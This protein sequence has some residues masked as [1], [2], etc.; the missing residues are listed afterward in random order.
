[1][2]PPDVGRE[3]FESI[4]SFDGGSLYWQ[5]LAPW[6]DAHLEV[7]AWLE[8]FAARPGNPV[9]PATQD[10]LWELYA[11][12]RVSQTL[13]LRFQSGRADG[14]DWQP[15]PLTLAEY[16][17]FFT[18]LGFTETGDAPFSP[19]HHEILAVEQ[20]ADDTTSIS[21]LDLVWPGL[22]L[23]DMVFSRA[24]VRVTGG[25]KWIDKPIAETSTLYWAH[26]RK[27]RPYQDESHG[28][29]SNSQW[30][31]HFRRD[32]RIGGRFHFN[33]DGRHEIGEAMDDGLTP[34]ERT[35]LVMHRCFVTT[36][37]PH[38]D[39]YPYILRY[40]ESVNA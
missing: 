1:M 38:D 19:F 37:N 8:A 28:W 17:A 20:S 2:T 3:L 7:R 16:T 27:N 9:P 40:T 11:L 4:H 5:L 14:T 32:Y 10:E 35:E 31:T 24:G 22:Q 12:S 21:V 30:R 15:P 23:G 6:V 13:L 26:R 33:A 36:T 34:A 25:R 29:G 39:L 18:A